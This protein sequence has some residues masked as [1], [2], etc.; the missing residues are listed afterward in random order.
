MRLDRL[1]YIALVV[2]AVI[3]LLSHCSH[4][5]RQD[6]AFQLAANSNAAGIVEHYIPA[7]AHRDY[8]VNALNDSSELLKAVDT[9]REKAEVKANDN[10]TAASKWRWVVGIGASLGLG[11]LVFGALKLIRG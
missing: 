10:A 11:A 3:V 8:V 1:F 5:T 4:N 9:E 2:I 7:G 6:V